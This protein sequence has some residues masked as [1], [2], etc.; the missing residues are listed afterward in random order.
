MYLNF[1]TEKENFYTSTVGSTIKQAYWNGLK[2]EYLLIIASRLV[3]RSLR[4]YIFCYQKFIVRKFGDLNLASYFISLI[5]GN[6]PFF[7]LKVD[8][9]SPSAPKEPEKEEAWADKENDVNHLT[10]DAFDGFIKANPSVLVMFYAPCKW[11]ASCLRVE[12]VC[13]F[14]SIGDD[15]VYAEKE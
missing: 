14:I 9:C 11:D 7:N 13:L 12:I 15:K 10:S 5:C 2:S 4:C 6:T 3:K 8:G 1:F